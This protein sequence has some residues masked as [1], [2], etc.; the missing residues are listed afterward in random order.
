M[1]SNQEV[2]HQLECIIQNNH[3]PVDDQQAIWLCFISRC[4]AQMA[5]ELHIMNGRQENAFK[6]WLRDK[7]K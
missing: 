3:M 2:Y 5:D 1:E 7:V 4:I 6:M